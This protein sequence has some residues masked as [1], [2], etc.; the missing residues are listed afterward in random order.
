MKPS[1]SNQK[2]G[3]ITSSL[4]MET[5]HFSETSR[6]HLNPEYHRC[7]HHHENLKS[8][9]FLITSILSGSTVH[10]NRN[11]FQP[12]D[13]M[14]AEM[15]V[16]ITRENS[17]FT[18]QIL[19]AQPLYQVTMSKMKALQLKYRQTNPHFISGMLCRTSD[20][21]D[22]FIIV[23]TSDVS[24]WVLPSSKL[25]YWNL[26]KCRNFLWMVWPHLTSAK[27]KILNTNKGTH[28]NLQFR[29]WDIMARG[30]QNIQQFTAFYCS[31]LF[32]KK[33]TQHTQLKGS[34]SWDTVPLVKHIHIL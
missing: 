30:S 14:E 20:S 12:K 11:I 13:C 6:Q 19:P 10:Q 4:K 17:V 29:F 33:I 18:R 21:Q 16:W 34:K 8:W 25:L 15:R 7:H 1:P 32:I 22:N 3:F 9:L 27:A 5:A 2:P 28:H 24:L 26:M 31:T 23:K